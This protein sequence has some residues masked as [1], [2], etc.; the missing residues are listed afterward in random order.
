MA[1]LIAKA[2]QLGQAAQYDLCGACGPSA[3]RV[4]DDL[5]RWIYPA[6]LPDG[7]TV[8]LFKVLLTNA[9]ERDCAYCANR[10]GR[11]SRRTTLTPDELAA[12]FD[13]LVRRDMATGLF[14]SSAVSGSV[15]SAMERMI[16]AVEIVRRKYQ[17]RGYVHLKVLPGAERAAVERATQLAQRVSVNLEAP[18]AER[19]ARLS[20]T[21]DFEQDLLQR[22]RWAREVMLEQGTARAGQTTQFVVGAAGESDREIIATTSRLYRELRLARAYFSAFQPVPGTPLEGLPPTSAIREHRLYQCDF[23]LRSYGFGH[24]EIVYDS[25]GNLPL[26]ADPKLVWARHHPEWFPVDINRADREALLRVPGIG[27]RS[28]GRILLARRHGTLRDLESLRRLG[29][30]VQRAAPFVLLG[31]RRP[32]MQLTL[33]PQEEVQ[34]AGPAGGSGLR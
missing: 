5:G 24:E 3:S 32:P 33:W 21:K 13:E 27:P 4:R 14:L 15:A 2:T 20:T 26:D 34:P 1:D 8:R 9:C 6:A 10:A 16:A 30:L 29:V 11:D 17:F 23:M 31:G 22:M 12:V 18:N 19:L 7:R 25:L 28:A